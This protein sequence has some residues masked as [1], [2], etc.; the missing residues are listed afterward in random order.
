MVLDANPVILT[1]E[2]PTPGLAK[3]VCESWPGGT[4][5]SG[6]VRETQLLCPGFFG[7]KNMVEI[8]GISSLSIVNQQ[9]GEGL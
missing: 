5:R 6:W 7:E 1:G 4:D 2:L 9:P 8:H 3:S